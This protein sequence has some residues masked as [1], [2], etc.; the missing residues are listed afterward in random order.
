VSPQPTHLRRPRP[1]RR[2]HARSRDDTGLMALEM[3]ILAPVAIVMLLVVVAFG[4]VTQGRTTVD[5]AA[6][7][8]A[9]AASLARS[10]GQADADAEQAAR[11]TLSGAGLSCVGSSVDIDTTAF[12]PGGQVTASVVCTVDLSSLALAGLPGSVTLH[13]SATSPIEELRDLTGADAP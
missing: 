7:A 13:A 12:R 10:A 4:R 1:D 6:A 2:G 11:D 9:R 8:A 5:Q 3:A